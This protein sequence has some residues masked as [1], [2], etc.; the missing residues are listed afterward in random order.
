[1]YSLNINFLKDR[2]EF[3][4]KSGKGKAG[5]SGAALAGK[6]PLY[7]GVA[8]GVALPALVAGLL[9]YLIL[10][11]NALN[12]NQARLDQSLA[13]L[14]A[15]ID[16][17]KQAEDEMKVINTQTE[18]LAGVFDKVRAWSAILGDIR[19]R[20]PPGVQ[21]EAIREDKNPA[22]AAT[23]AKPS[24]KPSASPSPGAS[25]SAA[26]SP[27]AA[28]AVDPDAPP[29]TIIRITGFANSVDRV[30]ELLL[31]LQKSPFFNPKQ[32][33]LVSSTLVDNPASINRREV[34]QSATKELPEGI[35][36]TIQN[37]D[38]MQAAQVQD[39]MLPPVVKYEIV[40]AHTLDTATKLR[41]ALDR[42]G[43]SGLVVRLETIRS[44]LGKPPEPMTPS[45]PPTGLAPPAR[46]PGGSPPAAG[47][48]V[49]SG[50]PAP[51]AS[52]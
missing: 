12:E 39:G 38:E 5:K 14:Q 41:S 33:K 18:G 25:P 22:A 31:L 15:E 40:T 35:T 4:S 36:Y 50:V 3:Q 26:A 21:V 23:A 34:N 37:P 9:G 16:R 24:P 45:S 2:P 46:P 30:G 27:A 20:L 29:A 11:I 6:T 17:A 28:P 19:D 48:P 1:M 8:V 44:I 52:R 7:A 32:T 47:A 51:A 42:G 43:A 13:V 49:T 10:Q